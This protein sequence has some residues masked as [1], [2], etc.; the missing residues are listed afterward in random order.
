[1]F[2]SYYVLK[3]GDLIYLLTLPYKPDPEALEVKNKVPVDFGNV[4][5]KSVGFGLFSLHLFPSTFRLPHLQV[6]HQFLPLFLME[7]EITFMFFA[8]E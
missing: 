1:M 4:G 8:S 5:L 7:L 2:L 3:A 6:D